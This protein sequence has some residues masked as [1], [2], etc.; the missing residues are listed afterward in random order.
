VN[1]EHR[2]PEP[3]ERRRSRRLPVRHTHDSE[4][5]HSMKDAAWNAFVAEYRANSVID[6]TTHVC[7]PR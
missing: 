5:P 6:S 1:L 3:D 2:A 7:L 4:V